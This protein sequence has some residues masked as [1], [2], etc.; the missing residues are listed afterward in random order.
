MFQVRLSLYRGSN[1]IIAFDIDETFQA[2]ALGKAFDQALAMLP[3][4]PS[5]IAGDADVKRPIRSVRYD[6]DPPALHGH[7]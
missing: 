6:V 7:R 1:F 3:Y 4:A 5:K 2:I